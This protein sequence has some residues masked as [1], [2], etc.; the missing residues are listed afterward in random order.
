MI[1]NISL[2]FFIVKFINGNANNYFYYNYFITMAV[3]LGDNQWHFSEGVTYLDL[4]DSFDF[5]VEIVLNGY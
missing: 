4:N 3:R 2:L 1:C 5:I